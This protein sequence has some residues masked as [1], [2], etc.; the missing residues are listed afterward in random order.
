MNSY[1]IKS[2]RFSIQSMT[3]PKKLPSTKRKQTLNPIS[4]QSIP[5]LNRSD[6]D[7]S[8]P[9]YRRGGPFQRNSVERRSL[10]WRRPSSALSCKSPSSTTAKSA[11]SS[12]H[13]GATARTSLD[14]ELDLQAQHARLTNLHDELS[15]LREL[16][17]RLEQAR[18][19]GDPDMATWLLEDD[20][21]QV[22]MQ[23][24]EIGKNGKSPEDKKVDKM[25]RKTSKEIYK[26]RK[27]KAG[28]GKPD[29]ISFK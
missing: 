9:L 25:L 17:S 19:R 21:F 24:A 16:K 3:K 4:P 27:T 29:I 11:K 8:M 6:S 22:L 20:K 1:P 10:R 18:E 13:F 5:Q 23:Q 7:S 14:L 2:S 28:K 15:R 26:L 12:G